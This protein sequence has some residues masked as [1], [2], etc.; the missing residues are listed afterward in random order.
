MLKSMRVTNKALNKALKITFIN[1]PLS[2]YLNKGDLN[3]NLFMCGVFFVFLA[4]LSVSFVCYVRPVVGF[5]PITQPW[6]EPGLLDPESSALTIRAP[7]LPL[8]DTSHLQNLVT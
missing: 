4:V 1:K 7:H 2:K 5:S 3:V 6:L 8:I